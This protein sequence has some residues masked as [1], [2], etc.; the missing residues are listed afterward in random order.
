MFKTSF[1]NVNVAKM[2]QLQQS[3]NEHL[4]WYFQSINLSHIEAYTPCRNKSLFTPI[5]I[6]HTYAPKKEENAVV[7][8]ENSKTIFM[9]SIYIETESSIDR[10]KKTFFHRRFKTKKYIQNISFYLFADILPHYTISFNYTFY[11]LHRKYTKTL[12]YSFLASYTYE[13]FI[14]IKIFPSI[15]KIPVV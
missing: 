6:S 5:Y 14:Q 15:L 8:P 9:S 4:L 11:F 1:A 12:S 3:S 7:Y 2:R 13:Q 10:L